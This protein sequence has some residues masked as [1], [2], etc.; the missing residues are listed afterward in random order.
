MLQKMAPKKLEEL[1][2][3]LAAMERGMPLRRAAINYGVPRSTLHRN[4]QTN[5]KVEATAGAPTI[6]KREEEELIVN[7]VKHL[8]K[9]AFPVSKETFMHSV[10]TLAAK[11]GKIFP[12]GKTTPGRKWY[13]GFLRRNPEITMRTSQNLT[14]VRSNVSQDAICNWFA[15]IEGFLVENDLISVLQ[16]PRRVFNADETAF[17][18]NPKPGKVLAE[19]GSKSIY[20]QGG[21]DEKF[22][23]TVLVT[24]NAA[25]ELAPPMI[26]YRYARIPQNIADLMPP[27][28]AIG[29]SENG[30]MTQETFFEY[31]TNVFDPW[32]EK[33]LIEKPVIFF[34]DGH[35]SHLSLYLTE[36]CM[37]K[38]IV[39]VALLPNAT[40]LLQP[41]DVSVFHSLKSS[42]KQK[43][44]EYRMN[45][46]G[47]QIAK[48][49]FAPVLKA[50]LDE[51][52]PQILVSGFRACGLVPWDPAKVKVPV[53]HT[54]P[55]PPVVKTLIHQPSFLMVLEQKIGPEKLKTFQDC[56]F[57]NW[58]GAEEDKSL[59]KI[60]KETKEEH[61][62][63]AEGEQTVS[64]FTPECVELPIL[65]ADET[66]TQT[67]DNPVLEEFAEETTVPEALVQE[68]EPPAGRVLQDAEKTPEKSAAP[69]GVPSPFKSTLFW[70]QAKEA[71]KKRNRE[72][73]P[74]VVTSPQMLAYYKRKEAVRQE[75][76]EAIK[77]RKVER[78]EKKKKAKE[79][80]L[81]NKLK[82]KI[83]KVPSVEESSSSSP[84]P[85]PSYMESEDSPWNEGS[86]DEEVVQEVA[87]QELAVGDFVLVNF[88]GGNRQKTTYTYAC[89]VQGVE[90]DMVGVQGMRSLSDKRTF[91]VA[92]NDSSMVCLHEI[93]GKLPEATMKLDGRQITYTFKKNVPVKEK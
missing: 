75:K 13:E 61:K 48:P 31:I 70:P 87:L 5:Q 35:V 57:M 14:S 33:N 20:T 93:V 79:L 88:V 47:A 18:L 66:A 11:M 84:H 7:W 72:K 32:L 27:F 62:G 28:W 73:L 2:K 78:E 37:E 36:Y 67:E 76:E 41:M 16:D 65:P 15:E 77:R 40:H 45:N 12:G 26:V 80:K 69:P 91:R 34:L 50:L 24:G 74:S 81:N 42:W 6:F 89:I 1:K 59:Y 19:K 82:K 29:K 53:L 68:T 52:E 39:L 71:K 51:M 83:K 58:T 56:R 92:D 64:S 25:G 44:A 55:P 8:Q 54:K 10:A 85:S 4:A 3:A 46:G 90:E 17:F 60:W 49:E 86:S 22:N 63:E 21:A 38:K 9:C 30:W 23:I 43:V